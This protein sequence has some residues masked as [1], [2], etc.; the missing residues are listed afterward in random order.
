MHE[1]NIIHNVARQ[2]R[3]PHID[4]GDA[5]ARAARLLLQLLDGEVVATKN[6]R[7]SIPLL[8]RGNEMITEPHAAG[9]E[10]YV[11]AVMRQ[12][13][14]MEIEDPAVLAAGVY[15]G[16]PFTDV[17]ELSSQVIVTYDAAAPAGTEERLTECLTGEPHVSVPFNRQAADAD[18]V[19]QR[20][21]RKC[22]TAERSCKQH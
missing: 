7:I 2:D 18:W 17:P 15:W 10:S 11:G 21:H 4:A 16:N 9:A 19:W 13:V 3:Y 1:T 14:S 20:W 22:G 5:G 8:C 6:L 12:A